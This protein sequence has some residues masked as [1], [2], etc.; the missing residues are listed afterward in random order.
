MSHVLRGLR[1]SG[2]AVLSD[3]TVAHLALSLCAGPAY[4]RMLCEECVGIVCAKRALCPFRL[5]IESGTRVQ[6]APQPAAI[7]RTT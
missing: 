5:G 1:A 3:P 4:R 6:R 2:I 7:A